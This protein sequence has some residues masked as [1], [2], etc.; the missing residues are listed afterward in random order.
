MTII[1]RIRTHHFLLDKNTTCG[2]CGSERFEYKSRV[3]KLNI[4]HSSLTVI[5]GKCFIHI[6]S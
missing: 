4:N 6:V 2:L 1:K 3:R 5:I